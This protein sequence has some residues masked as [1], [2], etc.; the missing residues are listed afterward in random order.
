MA[1]MKPCKE[2]QLDQHFINL[3]KYTLFDF[4]NINN[5]V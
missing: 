5:H 3:E 1:T 4:W 2:N